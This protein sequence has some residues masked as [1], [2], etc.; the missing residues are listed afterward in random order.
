MKV[1]YLGLNNSCVKAWLEITDKTLAFLCACMGIVF[2][3][4][5]STDAIRNK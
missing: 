1:S 2:A 3:S 5:N 4:V